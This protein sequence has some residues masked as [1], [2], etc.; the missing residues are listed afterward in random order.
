MINV[1]SVTA[2]S[3]VNVSSCTSLEMWFFRKDF[4]TVKDVEDFLANNT[5]ISRVLTSC[6]CFFFKFLSNFCKDIS[7]FPRAETLSALIFLFKFHE[8]DRLSLFWEFF[9]VLFSS[10]LDPFV[11]LNHASPLITLRFQSSLSRWTWIYLIIV[12]WRWN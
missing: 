11:K 2:V 8:F 12:I 7:K 4:S 3:R 5:S 1:L 9:I 10:F 6:F